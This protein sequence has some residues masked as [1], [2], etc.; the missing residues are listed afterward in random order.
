MLAIALW[1]GL[2]WGLVVFG[3]LHALFLVIDALTV[4]RRTKF[5]RDHNHWNRP[6]D[7]GGW[8]L[9]FHQVA[10]SLV[11]FRARSVPDALWLFSHVL[12]G[13]RLSLGPLAS[14]QFSRPLGIGLTGYVAIELSERFRPDAWLRKA[15][16]LWPRWMQWS[17]YY[18]AAL[19]LLVG[20]LLFLAQA[21]GPKSA[22][23]YEI[24]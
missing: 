16:P 11:F 1:H 15:V 14:L 24:F 18:A 12:Q 17:Y 20:L 10:I 22:F 13:L 5:F 9:T 21:G 23:L 8:L 3:L 6:A 7:W 19:V 2:A 4:R